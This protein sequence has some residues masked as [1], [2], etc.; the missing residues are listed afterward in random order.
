MVH[1]ILERNQLLDLEV[2]PLADNQPVFFQVFLINAHPLVI[3]QFNRLEKGLYR[4]ILVIIFENPERLLGHDL[5]FD[6]EEMRL[7]VDDVALM[8]TF[9]KVLTL[10][11]LLDPLATSQ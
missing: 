9:T 6:V 11:G 4:G 7:G 3:D 8:K 10:G 5:K 2:E 1:K